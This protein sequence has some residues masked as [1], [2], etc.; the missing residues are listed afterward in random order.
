MILGDE[1]EHRH[2]QATDFSLFRSRLDEETDY[3]KYAF[4]ENEFSERGDIVG[5]EL[6]ACLIDSAGFPSPRNKE[7]LQK[8]HNPLVVPE[9]AEF[10]VELNGSPAA[11]TGNVFS[12]LY[13]ELD[14]TWQNCIEVA[15][16]L[17]LGVVAIG[18][19]PTIQP[20][21]LNSN[22]MSD[23]VRYQALND[24][25]MALR[26][27][28]PLSIQ[29]EHQDKLDLKHDDVMMEAATTSFQIHLQCKPHRAVKDF[30]ATLIASAPMVALSANSP[31]LFGKSLWH[32][33]RIPLFEQ[34][35]AL[36]DRYSP[37]VNFATDYVADSVFEVFAE[38][39]ASHVLLLPFVQQEPMM[40][41]AHLRFHNGTI[42]RWNRPLIGFD[43]DGQIH[44]RIEHRCVPAG[45][46]ILD[47][48]ANCA[49][50]LGMVRALSDTYENVEQRLPFLHVRNNFYNAAK[51][52]M[53]AEFQWLDG[54]QLTAQELILE[55]LL[56]AAHQALL[57]CNIP[58]DEV[59]RFLNVIQE[60]VRSKQNGAQWQLDWTA[61]YGF[62]FP[63]LTK[64]YMAHQITNEPVH[65]WSLK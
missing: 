35:V 20:N 40:K 43:Y 38:N 56:P 59:N 26:D 24:R 25:V 47:S 58:E 63:N 29:I 17:E 11:L 46:S 28:E 45:P 16:D 33:T 4:I 57:S 9:L 54:Q 53:E 7:L 2:F 42:W 1:I 13:E 60:R 12:H 44:L 55:E 6:E 41:Y 22:Y 3:I 15:N 10:N 52:G 21:L 39:Q 18:I 61:K 62:D 48:I 65:L 8:L 51:Y 64:A 49:C 27:G 30:N 34:A 36:G 14:S 50:F 19:L 37:R 32:E 31:F 23:M 5:F